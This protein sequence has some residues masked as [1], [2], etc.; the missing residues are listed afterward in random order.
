METSDLLHV[1]SRV[2]L[3]MKEILYLQSDTNYTKVFTTNGKMVYSSTS[4][5]MIENRMAG[6]SIFIRINKGLVVNRLYIKTIERAEVILNNNLSLSVSRRRLKAF[7]F[8][9]PNL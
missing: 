3:L 1:G 8:L 9:T 6:N 5:K 4:L 7:K 2:K